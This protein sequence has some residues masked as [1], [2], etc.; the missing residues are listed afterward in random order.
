M[1]FI[2]GALVVLGFL[3][4]VARFIARDASGE[5]R[6]PRVV[7]ESI[8]MWA[9]RRLTGRRLGMPDEDGELDDD[10][11]INPNAA[12]ATRAALGAVLAAS[13]S[14]PA[15]APLPAQPAILRDAFGAER[16]LDRVEPTRRRNLAPGRGRA[17]RAARSPHMTSATPVLDL[18]RRQRAQ[19]SRRRSRS[20]RRLTAL[21]AIA[22]VLI[23]AVAVGAAIGAADRSAGLQGEVLAA[24]GRPEGT[25]N[26]ARAVG[27]SPA[28][29]VGPRTSMPA[30]SGPL[31]AGSSPSVAPPIA[32][33]TCS[34]LALLVTC[35][36]SGSERAVAYAFSFGSGSTL[37]GSSPIASNQYAIAGTY[38][39]TLTVTDAAG[40]PG[41]T[42]DGFTI[43][44]P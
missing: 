9:L 38:A 17:S 36:G 24:T 3:A 37:S 1:E 23:V 21:A 42:P 40:H 31:H 18:R 8:G 25:A 39:I 13:A 7:N 19:V 41:L 28:P 5:V 44:I 2:V 33:I 10:L 22:A 14:H 43:T 4:I 11:V 15:A 29:S 34:S 12:D 26:A 27:L 6:L 30:A 35:D 32:S 16:A 20:A